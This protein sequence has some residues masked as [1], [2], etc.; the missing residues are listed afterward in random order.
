MRLETH[1][2]ALM[3]EAD[4]LS[5]QTLLTN[6][7]DRWDTLIKFYVKEKNTTEVVR[8]ARIAIKEYVLTPQ[9]Y[10]HYLA[11]L[12][13]KNKINDAIETIDCL[14]Q[15]LKEDFGIKLQ[16]TR[17]LININKYEEAVKLARELLEQN[18]ND[19]S[20]S[21]LLIISL[22]RS[23]R[24]EELFRYIAH[25]PHQALTADWAIRAMFTLYKKT[26]LGET[27]AVWDAIRKISKAQAPNETLW[28]VRLKRIAG[29]VSNARREL[30]QRAKESCLD[31]QLKRELALCTALSADWHRAKDLYGEFCDEK[32]LDPDTITLTECHHR[33][34]FIT[35]NLDKEIIDDS[36]YTFPDAIFETFYRASKNHCYNPIK[37]RVAL[38]NGTMGGGGSE[39]AMAR[40]FLGMKTDFDFQ[41]ELWLY[42]TSAAHD[43]NVVLV[44]LNISETVE[45][46]VHVL[47][48]N[49]VVDAPF[50]LLPRPFS[51]NA[52]AIYQQILDR[53]PEVIHAWED[54]V[55]LEVAVAALLAGVRKIIIHPHNMRA[56]KVHTSPFVNSFRRAYKELIKRSEITFVS[57]S[58]AALTDYKDWA[59]LSDDEKL[60]VVYNGFEWDNFP[61]KIWIDDKRERFRETL[62]V[63]PN[64]KLVGGIFRFAALKRPYFW[65]DVAHSLSRLDSDIC[66][67]LFGA[68]G[69]ID[70]VKAYA[71]HLGIAQKIHFLGYV[72]SISTDIFALDA[73]LHTS[74][75]EGLPTAVI[76]AGSAGVE[77]VATKVGGVAECIDPERAT[78]LPLEQT[79]D[80]FSAA[81]FDVLSKPH[82]YQ[83]RFKSAM[84]IRNKFRIE[85]MLQKLR[86]IYNR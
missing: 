48:R 68:G 31:N 9:G 64:T 83:T 41:P 28:S 33:Y 6:A 1:H 67:V 84:L 20:S 71:A 10:A 65:I 29:F 59:A 2:Q 61:S 77:I 43:H 56:N 36:D 49:P 26:T 3:F 45:S 24:F 72:Q 18:E 57:V 32:S 5:N 15:D 76:D 39:K 17:L 11:A 63:A 73:L 8:I 66:F 4:I 53:R 46:G 40:A 12:I 75:T 38:V 19:P 25:A 7:I 86:D 58:H 50:N 35:Q 52:S 79:S 21:G 54:S 47:Q 81:L 60:H 44:G 85:H 34:Q 37:G 30:E 51:V 82:T 74:E 14:D 22:A 78:L 27:E 69:E 70:S 13:E 55:N 16:I 62:G 23:N 80:Q 42:S